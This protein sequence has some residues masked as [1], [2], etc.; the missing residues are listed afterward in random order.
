MT[1]WRGF[2]HKL[3]SPRDLLAKMEHDYDRMRAS[4]GDPYPVFDFFVAAEHMVDWRY[5]LDG[6]K[7]REVRSHDPCRTVSHLASGAKH[8][9]ATDA[10]HT[11]VATVEA[12]DDY[13]TSVA[14]RAR[15]GEGAWGSTGSPMMVVT[16]ADGRRVT[17]L[18]LA[19]LVIR[20][21]TTELGAGR[22]HELSD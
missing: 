4:P 2:S 22:I 12:E 21:W 13:G 19:G 7:Q 16:M 3:Q 15:W 5:P 10:R 18:E 9:E 20:Y 6:P 8:F 11:S 14:D 1:G 17:S